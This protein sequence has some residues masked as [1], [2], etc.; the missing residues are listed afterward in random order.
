[1]SPRAGR[2]T[3]NPKKTR[4]ELRLSNDDTEKLEYCHQESGLSKAE[5]LRKGLDLVYKELKRRMYDF[6]DIREGQ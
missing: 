6:K 2:P 3:D 4:L 1:M 5:I